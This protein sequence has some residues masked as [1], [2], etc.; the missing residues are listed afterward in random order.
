MTGK[1]YASKDGDVSVNVTW[2]YRIGSKL[3]EIRVETWRDK[4]RMTLRALRDEPD[5]LAAEAAYRSELRRPSFRGAFERW[6]KTDLQPYTRT[7]GKRAGRKDTGQLVIE[8]VT[9][10]AFR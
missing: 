6:R 2:R 3:R 7:N 8:Q 5:G 9:R 10:H 1:V 4:G